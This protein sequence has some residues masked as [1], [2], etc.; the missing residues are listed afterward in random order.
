VNINIVT[1]HK[2]IQADL[3]TLIPTC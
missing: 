3:M 1:G 2:L